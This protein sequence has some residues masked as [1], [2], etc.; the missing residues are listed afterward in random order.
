MRKIPEQPPLQLYQ[1]LEEEFLSLHGPLPYQ[2]S[3]LFTPEQLLQDEQ[4]Q[5]RWLKTLRLRQDPLSAYLLQCLGTDEPLSTP[6]LVE[7]LNSL[8]R[9][10]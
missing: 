9:G 7:Q 4:S 3:W 2:P 8:L 5:T 1:V 6:T 10:P